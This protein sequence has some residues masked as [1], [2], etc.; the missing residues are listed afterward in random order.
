MQHM[1][2]SAWH[3]ISAQKWLAIIMIMYYIYFMTMRNIHLVWL[4]NTYFLNTYYILGIH[5]KWWGHKNESKTQFLSLRS[6]QE[7]GEKPIYT[8]VN[9]I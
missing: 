4:L 6:L 2:Q 5:A 3:T 8:D 9:T 1:K 7:I